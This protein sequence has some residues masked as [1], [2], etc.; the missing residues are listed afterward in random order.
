MSWFVGD[1]KTIS[2]VEDH[3]ISPIYHLTSPFREIIFEEDYFT[4]TKF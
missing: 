4:E 1:H 3:V 2:V